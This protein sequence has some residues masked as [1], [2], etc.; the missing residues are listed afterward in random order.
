MSN[1]QTRA[2]YKYPLSMR[3]VHWVRALVVIAA[4]TIGL[5]MVNLPEDSIFQFDYLYPTHKQLGVFAFILAIVQ[6]M[7]HRM[8][9][10]PSL[11]PGLPKWER[12]LSKAVHRLLYALLILVPVLGYSM[13]S[14]F[15]QSDGVPFLF[16]HLPELLPKNDDLFRVFQ[17]AHRYLS[18]AFAAAIA[19]HVVGTLKHRYLDA[20]KANDVLPRMV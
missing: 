15:T 8:N 1:V 13:S 3:S 6:L 2:Q 18:Y 12:V 4:L 11:P 9:V 17:A 14:S 19:L 7:L 16:F 5:V 10:T 20:D